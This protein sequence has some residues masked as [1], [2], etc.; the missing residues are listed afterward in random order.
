ME[1]KKAVKG[2]RSYLPNQVILF[3]HCFQLFFFF[4]R[5][6]NENEGISKKIIRLCLFLSEGI[7]EGVLLFKDGVWSLLIRESW[8]LLK[9]YR[10]LFSYFFDS[11]WVRTR[12]NAGDP[13]A[14]HFLR[15]KTNKIFNDSGPLF[16]STTNVSNGNYSKRPVSF[17]V[18]G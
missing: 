13:K 10:F 6:L 9:S 1:K 15:A 2:P 14:K 4:P 18:L 8:L 12:D 3:F 7:Q 11:F 17:D 16:H 5:H